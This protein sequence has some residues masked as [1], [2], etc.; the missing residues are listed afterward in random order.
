MS[1][2]KTFDCPKSMLFKHVLVAVFELG[3]VLAIV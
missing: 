2:E 3:P 1:F